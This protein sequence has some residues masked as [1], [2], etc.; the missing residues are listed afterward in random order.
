MRDL[1][2]ISTFSIH[3][4]TIADFEVSRRMLQ[5]NGTPI[6]CFIR[7]VLHTFAYGKPEVLNAD[8]RMIV[9][10]RVSEVASSATCH[11]IRYYAANT[12]V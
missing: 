1:K 12:A 8:V 6:V 5:L 4:S 11:W 7:A 10:I 3:R 2:Q 9:N